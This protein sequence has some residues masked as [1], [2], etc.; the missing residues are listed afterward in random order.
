MILPLLSVESVRSVVK[1]LVWLRRK[2]ALGVSW[3]SLRNVRPVVGLHGRRKKKDENARTEDIH[4]FHR[5]SQIGCATVEICEN[6]RNLW[7]RRD[8]VKNM[9]TGRSRG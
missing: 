2:A 6:L 9:A 5:F 4:R 1:K 7:F 3:L 8:G